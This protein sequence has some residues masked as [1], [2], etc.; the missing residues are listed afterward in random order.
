MERL[1]GP[2]P[3][4]DHDPGCR[5]VHPP[6]PPPHTARWIP[7]YSLLRSSWQPL[8]AT[9]PCPLSA[10]TGYG[11]SRIHDPERLSRPVR[12]IDGLLFATVP[13]LSV[14]LHGHHRELRRPQ[15]PG[16]PRY[17]MSMITY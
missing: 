10:A 17:F 5:R 1:P 9:K 3:T 7:A 14:R 4:Q 13:R 2:Q 16:D 12:T 15:I 6:F 11:V 8:P